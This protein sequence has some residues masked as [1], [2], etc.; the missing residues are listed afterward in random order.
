MNEF[1]IETENLTKYYG[2]Q[3]CV[4]NLNLHVPKEKIHISSYG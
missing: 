3:L 4:D 2:K 1:I